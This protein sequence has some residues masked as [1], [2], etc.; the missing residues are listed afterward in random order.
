MRIRLV[1]AAIMTDA[2]SLICR[3]ERLRFSKTEQAAVKPFSLLVLA[4][5][6]NSVPQ[7]TAQR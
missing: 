1:L 7:F 3:A 4:F 6:Q 2:A 5:A